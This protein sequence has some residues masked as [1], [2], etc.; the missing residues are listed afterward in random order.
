MY[1]LEVEVKCSCLCSFHFIL[2]SVGRGGMILYYSGEE[3]GGGSEDVSNLPK[4]MT[5]VSGKSI[6]FKRGL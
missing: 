2:A 3:G 4:A 5:P 1:C 6:P